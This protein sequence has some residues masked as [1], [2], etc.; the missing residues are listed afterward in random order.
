MK[1]EAEELFYISYSSCA[2]FFLSRGRRRI[3]PRELGAL[4]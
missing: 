4:G 2:I 3:L 1:A